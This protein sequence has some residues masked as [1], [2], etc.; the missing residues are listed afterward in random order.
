MQKVVPPGNR[1]TAE[2]V[3]FELEDSI[4][5]M[6]DNMRYARD[7]MAF[8][9]ARPGSYVKLLADGK[10]QMSDTDMEWRTNARFLSRA[11]G[12]VLVAGLGI[13]MVL[14]PLFGKSEVSS[15]T[16]LELNRDVVELVAPHV[17]HKKLRVL[18][19]DAKQPD[20]VLNGDKFDT[21]WLD[22]WHNLSADNLDEMKVL[23]ALYRKRLNRGG[24]VGCWSEDEVKRGVRIG[25]L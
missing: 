4:H 22:I 14:P 2:V 20:A 9:M 13:G 23:K 15:V 25:V 6:L 11:T 10:L 18:C 19:G 5:L 16:V 24:F 12:D 7:G 1:A 8:M 17:A 21:V 3:H